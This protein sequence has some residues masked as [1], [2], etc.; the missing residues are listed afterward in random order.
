VDKKYSLYGLPFVDHNCDLKRPSKNIVIYG[1]NMG[2]DNIMFG[3][4]GEVYVMDWGLSASLDSSCKAPPISERNAQAGTVTYMAPEQAVGEMSSIGIRTDVYLLGALLYEILADKPPHGGN[5]AKECL[6]NAAANVIQ[7]VE[8][9]EEFYEF[10]ALAQYAMATRPEDRIESVG[11]FKT[12]LQL[13]ISHYESVVQTIRANQLLRKA[14]STQNYSD[15]TEA[16]FSYRQAIAL[17]AGNQTTIHGLSE[18]SKEY[19]KAAIERG[20]FDVAQSLLSHDDPRHNEL[21]DQLEKAIEL[22]ERRK[23]LDLRMRF[24]FEL[25]IIMFFTTLALMTLFLWSENQNINTKIEIDRK[26]ITNILHEHERTVRDNELLEEN[27]L[28]KREEIERLHS[29]LLKSKNDQ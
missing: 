20:D 1:H 28:K 6:S 2:S 9:R 23:R 14:K 29:E 16:L 10:L 13:C 8:I 24:I 12:E 26:Q 7:H 18:A 27:N 15:F 5:D 3:D 17:Y 21:I 11:K 19:A 4:Y 22:R 25:V